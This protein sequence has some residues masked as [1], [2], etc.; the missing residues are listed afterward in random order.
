MN[1]VAKQGYK[2]FY[3]PDVRVFHPRKTTIRSFFGQFMGYGIGRGKQSRM[4]PRSLKPIHLLPSIFVLGLATLPISIVLGLTLVWGI[5]AMSLLA[6][7]AT[8]FLVSLG[9]ALREGK[10]DVLTHLPAIFVA[11]HLAYGIGLIVGLLEPTRR[12]REPT[13]PDAACTEVV[14]ISLR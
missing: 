11:L 8:T 12:M 1:Q 14:S 13:D 6:H 3:S 9:I 10:L 4:D 7:L 5:L 2:M